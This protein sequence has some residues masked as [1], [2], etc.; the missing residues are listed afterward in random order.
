MN[1]ELIR[2]LESYRSKY[3]LTYSQ[4]AIKLEIPENYIYRWRKAG[5][6]RGIYAR[7]IKAFLTG[8]D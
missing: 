7:L 8:K 4:L 1:D 6:I 3:Q 2:Q 5:R